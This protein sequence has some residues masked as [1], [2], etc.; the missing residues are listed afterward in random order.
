MVMGK[1]YSDGFTDDLMKMRKELSKDGS[2]DK[3]IKKLQEII[4]VVNE[5]SRRLTHLG[6]VVTLLLEDQKSIIKLLEKKYHV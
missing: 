1:K 3:I 5:H 2:N 6:N 4:D